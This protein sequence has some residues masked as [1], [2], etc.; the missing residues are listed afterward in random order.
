MTKTTKR[1]IYK[2]QKVGVIPNHFVGFNE[3]VE[4]YFAILI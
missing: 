1:H 4:G 2:A 3:M